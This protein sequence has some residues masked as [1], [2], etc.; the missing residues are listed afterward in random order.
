VPTIAR[1]KYPYL[2]TNWLLRLSFDSLPRVRTLKVP[3]L[4]IQRT[5]DEKVPCQ[6]SEQL[7]AG[8]PEPK[9]LLLIRGGDHAHSPEIGRVEYDAAVTTFVQTQLN[10]SINQ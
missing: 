6:M 10:R 3:V 5:L 8:A 9:K 2:P 7:Y 4:P 1:E